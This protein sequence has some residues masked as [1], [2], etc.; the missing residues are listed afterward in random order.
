MAANPQIPA[1]ELAPRFT[2]SR[3]ALADRCFDFIVCGAGSAGCTLA[4][5]LALAE[6][7]YSVLL[8]EAGVEA[9]KHPLV[10]TPNRWSQLAYSE[11][12]W[13]L[14]SEPYAHHIHA[15]A[16]AP[17]LCLPLRPVSPHK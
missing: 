10:T 14:E 8:I 17:P 1:A 5:R 16:P 4:R 6:A 2:A 3:A 12:D 7:R 11:V 15:P 13:S 9:Q